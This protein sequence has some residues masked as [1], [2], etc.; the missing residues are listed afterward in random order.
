MTDKIICAHCGKTIKNPPASPTGVYFCSFSCEVKSLLGKSGWG[1]QWFFTTMAWGLALLAMTG[2]LVR[3]FLG[4][5]I[6]NLPAYFGLIIVLGLII[7]IL[8][9]FLKRITR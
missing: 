3:A 4:T 1:F 5:P 6:T 7:A 2:L 8:T 9:V